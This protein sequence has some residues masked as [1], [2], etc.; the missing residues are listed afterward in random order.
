MEVIILLIKIFLG[1]FVA[2]I[3][4]S[5]IANYTKRIS[6]FLIYNIPVF[7]LFAIYLYIF[8]F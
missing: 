1:S 7:L 3:M 6:T 2:L 8:C 4:G 5:Y